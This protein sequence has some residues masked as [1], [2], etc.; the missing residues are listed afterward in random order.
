MPLQAPLLDDRTFSDIMTEARSLIPRYTAE[1]T[2]HNESDPGIT[3]TQL[4][5][6]MTEM[7]L[8]RVNRVPDANYIK[9]LQLLGIELKPA[10]PARVE[11]T[12][13]PARKDIRSFIVPKG[14]RVAVAGGQ[15]GPPPIFE[16]EEALVGLGASLKAIQSF[17]G[18]AYG[19]E[20][21]KNAAAGQWFYPFGPQAR[22]GSALLLGFASPVDFP[23][24]QINLAFTVRSEGL[25]PEGRHCD[26]DLSLAPTAATLAWE[27]WDGKYWSALSLDKDETRAFTRN[28]HVYFTGPGRRAVKDRVGSVQNEPLYW[29][30]CRLAA[31]EY[32]T[33][34]RLEMALT[35]TGRARQALTA[36]DEVLGGSDGRPNQSYRLASTPVVAQERPP[37][38]S[39]A[40]GRVVMVSSV[41]VEV[42]EGSGFQAWQEVD[43]FFA[44]RPDDPHFVCNRTTGDIRFGDGIRHGRIPVANLSHPNDNIV[45]RSVSVR[46][47]AAGQ[48]GRRRRDRASDLCRGGQE[49]DQPPPGQRWRGRRVVGRSQTPR[50]RQRRARIVRSRPRTSR[51]WR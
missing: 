49:R 25:K 42:D 15:D 34:P 31:G 3:L 26:M 47:R 44:S 4:F 36:R 33:P 12:F 43:D 37:K 51:R 35:N 14:A 2:D 39:T 46:Q 8:Y 41:Q 17:D 40:D 19:V 13:T 27:Y 18:F 48:R 5:A 50:P 16:L 28:G 7:L 20:T 29:L 6:W 9:F 22:E 21:A 30:R 10:T 23:D 32:E 1:W 24:T 45:A 38:L 11:L